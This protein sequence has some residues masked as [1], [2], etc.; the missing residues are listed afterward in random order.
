[1]AENDHNHFEHQDIPQSSG[2][3]PEA[4]RQIKARIETSPAMQTLGIKV[5]YLGPGNTHLKMKA[6]PK[7]MNSLGVMQGGFIC[8]LADAAMGF[9]VQTLGALGTTLDLNLNYIAPVAVNTKLI[10][11]GTILHLGRKTAVA[12]SSIYDE[13]GRLVVK[14]RATFFVL[15]SK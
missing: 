13:E 5:D 8:A 11:H 1:M 15:E 12:E 3:D 4:Y 7:C 2:I 10:A 6:T 14:S 9:A